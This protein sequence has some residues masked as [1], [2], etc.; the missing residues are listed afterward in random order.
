MQRANEAAIRRLAVTDSLTGL[1]NRASLQDELDRAL[2]AGPCAVLLLDLDRFKAVNDTLGH[3]VGDQLLIELGQRLTGFASDGR[4]VGRLGG[5]EF[6]F[7][8]PGCRCP[9]RSSWP[10][11]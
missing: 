2:A 8:L 10:N 6:L 4:T 7:V 11:G 5:D 9:T 1:A 3:L